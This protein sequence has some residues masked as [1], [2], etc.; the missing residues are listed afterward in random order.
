[1]S[2]AGLLIGLGC[3]SRL[4]FPALLQMRFVHLAFTLA[5]AYRLESV[6]LGVLRIAIIVFPLSHNRPNSSCRLSFLGDWF[7]LG[8][9]RFHEIS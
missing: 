8:L 5:V 7:T 9:V 6:W 2:V 3:K 1:M 4:L